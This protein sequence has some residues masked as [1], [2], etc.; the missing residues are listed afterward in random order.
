L[1]RRIA[2]GSRET[3]LLAADAFLELGLPPTYPRFLLL[4]NGICA[5]SNAILG[6]YA[7]NSRIRQRPYPDR[8]TRKRSSIPPT[9]CGG[10]YAPCGRNPQDHRGPP[11]PTRGQLGSPSAYPNLVWNLIAYKTSKKRSPSA[12]GP[13]VGAKPRRGRDRPSGSKP[14]LARKSSPNRA[15]QGG[16]NGIASAA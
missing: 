6:E 16:G 14:R 2:A 4:C 10:P 5:S 12:S 3:L 7:S 8:S 11:R 9:G 1:S 13:L 15:M